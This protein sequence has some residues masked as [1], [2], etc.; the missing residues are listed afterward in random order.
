MRIRLF[1]SLLLLLC[2]AAVPAFA[3][4]PLITD[5]TGTQG[6]G[7]F[8]V[9]LFGEYG[10]DDDERVTSKNSDLSATVTYGLIDPIDVVLS[11]PYQAWRTDGSDTISKDDGI[12]D[13]AIEAK[14]RFSEIGN[15]SFALKPGLTIPTGDDSRGLGS[16][17]ATY[18]VLFITT[19]NFGEER[20][21]PEGRRIET[22]EEKATH[23]IE[24]TVHFNAGYTRNENS[25]GERTN[26]WFFSAAGSVEFI[27]DFYVVADLGAQTNTDTTSGTYPA[28]FLA[29][30]IYSPA[31]NVDLGLGMKFGLNNA[32]TDYSVRGGIT[33]RF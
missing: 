28:Y 32:E 25:V 6:K 20:F 18:H 5:D 9:E 8:Q 29:G 1:L 30:L 3:A 24:W 27:E 17:K 22:P 26:L 31:E 2:L 23:H 4:I 15:W 13:L 11:V 33:F 19:Y 10:H 12:G 7:K 14:W 21:A 16:G